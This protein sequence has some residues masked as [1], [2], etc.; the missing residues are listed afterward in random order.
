MNNPVT[1]L[2]DFI[3][4]NIV[5]LVEPE[6]LELTAPMV[7]NDPASSEGIKT[8]GENG[9]VT[10]S[11]LTTTALATLPIKAQFVGPAQFTNRDLDKCKHGADPYKKERAM[12]DEIIE[13][14]SEHTALK[15]RMTEIE[16]KLIDRGAKLDAMRGI[17]GGTYNPATILTMLRYLPTVANTK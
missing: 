3:R 10:V 8:F 14:V 17:R 6:T 13:L 7:V 5:E 15:K 9:E 2:A 12:Q 16:A 1:K 11:P 4:T